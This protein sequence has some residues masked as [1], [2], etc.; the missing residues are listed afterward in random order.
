MRAS[1]LVASLLI[2]GLAATTLVVAPASAGDV[3]FG[4]H[5]DGPSGSSCDGWSVV[6]YPEAPV[7]E[8]PGE[9]STP[10]PPVCG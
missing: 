9:P 10:H 5:Q 7:P 2:V 4:G 1:R 6:S 3:C 8:A